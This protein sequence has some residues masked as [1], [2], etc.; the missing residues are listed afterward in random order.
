MARFVIADISDAKSMLQELRTIVPN[1]PNLQVQPDAGGDVITSEINRCRR[2]KATVKASS[3]VF[4]I[5]EASP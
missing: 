1:L 2:M 5:R 4:A 3:L